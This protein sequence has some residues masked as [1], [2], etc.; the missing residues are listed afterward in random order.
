MKKETYLSTLMSQSAN[1]P[2]QQ[3]DNN[4]HVLKIALLQRMPI[5]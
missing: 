4:I 1:A 2:H 5:P 3:V